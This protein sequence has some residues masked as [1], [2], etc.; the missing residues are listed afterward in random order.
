MK[1]WLRSLKL[2]ITGKCNIV[3]NLQIIFILSKELVTTRVS[4]VT[5]CHGNIPKICDLIYTDSPF[6]AVSFDSQTERY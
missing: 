3:N 1:G 6:S 5:F 4:N 2:S